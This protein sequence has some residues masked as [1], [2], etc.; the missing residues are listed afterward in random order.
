MTD[1]TGRRIPRIAALLP[2]LPLLL[3]GRRRA[4]LS[5]LALG[6]LTIA[7]AVTG[8][9]RI[10]AAF[11]ARRVDSW[12]ALVTLLACAALAWSVGLAPERFHRLA[13]GAAASHWRPAWR[14][15]RRNRLA[16]LGLYLLALICLATL[17]APFL[18][19]YGPGEIGDIQATR[20]LAPS[21]EHPLGTDKFG[22]DVLTRILYGARVS[23]SIGFVAV[24]ISITLGT[25]VGAVAGYAGGA[26]DNLL[27]RFVDMLISFP[28]LVLLITVIALFDASLI[29]I[30]LILGLTLW[31]ST[32]RIVRG[33]V[34][35]VREREFVEAARALGLSAPRI[36]FRHIIPNVMGPV[37]VAATLGLGNIILIEAG[38]SFLGLGVQPPTPSWGVIIREGHQFLT[39]AP[40][41]TTFAGLAIVVTVIAFNLVGDGLRDALDPRLNR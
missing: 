25:L 6:V 41:V 26:V 31:P 7:V 8:A 24:T 38:L 33:D 20:H 12:L 17:L 19:G 22:R 16:I 5:L 30:V 10:L 14:E 4:G 28:R 1:P 32:A 36:V 18:T 27:M 2:G 40:W 23:L 35:S 37:I 13:T 3:Q 34:L 9:D 21:L 15:F 39:S 11:S 29:L